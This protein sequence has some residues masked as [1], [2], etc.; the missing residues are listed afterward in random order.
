MDFY[1]SVSL[2]N[3]SNILSWAP[4]ILFFLLIFVNLSLFA[5][6]FARC[7]P[8]GVFPKGFSTFAWMSALGFFVC[9]LFINR[10]D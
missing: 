8:S 2:D 3:I 10:Y 1:G 9:L 5:L 4:V 7:Q 6:G